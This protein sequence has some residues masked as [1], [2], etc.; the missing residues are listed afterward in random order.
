MIEVK[1]TWPEMLR[2]A[3]VG[4]L[5]RLETVV[6]GKH[7][8][9]GLDPASKGWDWDI[10]GAIGELAY[11]KFRQIYWPGY[12]RGSDRKSGD[13]RDGDVDVEVRCGSQ[14]HYRLIVHEGDRDDLVNVLVVGDGNRG[15]TYW[16]VGWMYGAEAKQ[17]GSFESP[18]GGFKDYFV[19]Q[20]ALHKVER[21]W[22]PKAFPKTVAV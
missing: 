11:C 3:E 16:V 9:S 17:V 4:V 2:A 14:R 21:G 18:T 7:N 19:N 5:R 1:L 20:A 8:L 22:A 15:M 6:S 12:V 13:V 10:Q